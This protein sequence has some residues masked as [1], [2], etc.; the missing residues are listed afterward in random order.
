MRV[1]WGGSSSFAGVLRAAISLARRLIS[2][3]RRLTCSLIS[4][5]SFVRAAL[6]VRIGNHSK[7]TIV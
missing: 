3:A 5:A 6:T 4:F 2:P 7:K 1:G